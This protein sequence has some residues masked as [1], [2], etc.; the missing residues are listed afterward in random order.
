MARGDKNYDKITH[1]LTKGKGKGA[2]EKKAALHKMVEALIAEKTDEAQ[3]HLHAYLKLK[4]RDIL[5]G[6]SEDDAD[7]KIKDDEK[8]EKSDEEKEDKEVDTKDSEDDKEEKKEEKE[9]KDD[10]VDEAFGQFG[11]GEG[12]M[13]RKVQGKLDFKGGKKGS[14]ALKHG[15][16][17]PELSDKID[18]DIKFDT[19]GSSKALKHGNNAPGLEDKP[20]GNVYKK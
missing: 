15:N 6:E 10:K 13:S 11:H 20:K 17:A 12:A 7:E 16:A 9:V 19:N 2:K 14:R 4:T 18:G 5:V 8:E 3:T 1:G